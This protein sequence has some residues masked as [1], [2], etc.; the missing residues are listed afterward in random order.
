M[1]RLLLGRGGHA[2]DPR[3]CCCQASNR[4]AQRR[5]RHV[6]QAHLFK[7]GDGCGV[8]PVLAADAQLNVGASLAAALDRQPHHLS[9][10]VNIDR[11]KRVA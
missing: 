8:A 11:I 3:L 1:R 6:V 7:E 2:A 4:H 5:A 9:H 10:A